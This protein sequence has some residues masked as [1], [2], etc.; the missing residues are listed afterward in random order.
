MSLEIQG[1][2]HVTLPE[3]SGE[4]K[5]GR[6][7][8]QD[9]VVESTEGKYPKKICFTAWG[10]NADIVK[11]LQPGEMLTVTFNPE[12]N[13]FKGRWYT[14]LRAWKIERGSS[15]QQDAPPA[16]TSADIPPPDEEDLP[17]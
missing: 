11:T 2:V 13:E 7:V 14:N 10:D 12:S 8:K 5:N 16:F 9:F 1:K 6:W 15:N 3:V 4:G 17:F